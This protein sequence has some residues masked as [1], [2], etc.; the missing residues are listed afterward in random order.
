[1]GPKIV[2]KPKGLSVFKSGV[3]TKFGAEKENNRTT[4]YNQ[5]LQIFYTSAVIR[6]LSN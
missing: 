2:R 6:A 4:V 1:M 3:V 5:K